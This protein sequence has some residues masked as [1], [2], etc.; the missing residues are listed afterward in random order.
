[1]KAK[2]PQLKGAPY[3]YHLSADMMRSKRI[4]ELILDDTFA[5]ELYSALCNIRWVKLPND[6]Q[7]RTQFVLA[8]DPHA[9]RYGL[10]CFGCTFRGAG[11]LVAA[12]RNRSNNNH[13]S[14]YSDWYM[15]DKRGIVSDRVAAELLNI[16]WIYTDIF[17]T[18]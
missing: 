18:F 10:D 15:G 2:K 16:G 6:P 12:L 4:L 17:G 9:L 5:E 3:K 14:D 7:E 1:M 13:D 11:E 8:F